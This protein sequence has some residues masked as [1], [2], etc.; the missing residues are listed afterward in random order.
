MT[1]KLLHDDLKIDINAKGTYSDKNAIDEG[2]ALGSALSMD[3]TKP[4]YDDSPS[5][6]LEDII[7]IQKLMDTKIL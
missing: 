3:P 5:N 7:K 2:G 1:P 6:I 4:V